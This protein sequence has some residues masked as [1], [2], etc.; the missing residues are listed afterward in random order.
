MTHTIGPDFLSLDTAF[1]VVAGG[2]KVKLGDEA[3]GRVALCR[4]FLDKR[5][6]NSDEAIYGINTGFGSLCD[7]II[8]PDSLRLLQ[9]NLVTSHACG[10]GPRVRPEIVR[11]M[12][13]LKVQGLSYGHSGVTEATVDRLIWHLNQNLL[14]VIYEQGSL[15]ASGDLAPLAHLSLPLLGLGE[16]LVLPLPKSKVSVSPLMIKPPAVMSAG[17]PNTVDVFTCAWSGSATG[18]PAPMRRCRSCRSFR[19]VRVNASCW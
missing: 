4:Q 16:V 7:T 2:M 17:V 8:S 14:P 18:S 19:S 1:Q 3:R 5:L 10:T 6:S 12:L 15:G 11:L 13:L 9:K